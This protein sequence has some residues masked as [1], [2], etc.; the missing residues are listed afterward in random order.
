LLP[1]SSSEPVRH[2]QVAEIFEKDDG[3]GYRRRNTILN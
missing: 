1:D 3:G 2:P